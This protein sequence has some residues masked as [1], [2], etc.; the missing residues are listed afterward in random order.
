[1]IRVL[2]AEDSPTLRYLIRS[3][4]E[5]DP[6]LEVVGAASNGEEAW[7]LLRELQPDIM[8]TDI[9]MPKLDGYGLIRKAMAEAPLPIVVLTSTASDAELGVTFH[10][11]EAGALMVTGKPRGL[12]GADPQADKLIRQVKAMARVKV[13]RRRRQLR[14][15]ERATAPR[16]PAAHR[17]G[18]R[19]VRV[20][21]MGASTG[22][23]PAIQLIL[24]RLPADL[25]VPIVVV[26]HI[27]AGFMTGMA[28]W[29]N[30]TT[31]PRV[32]IAEDGAALRAGTVY[33]APDAH[34][35]RVAAD[36][37]IR[38]SDCAPVGGHRPS[39]T[40][41]FE[42]LARA[43][44]PSAVGVLLTGMGSDGASGM[45]DLHDAGAMTLAQNEETCVVFGMPKQAITLGGV[46]EVL[47]VDRIPG[48]LVELATADAESYRRTEHAASSGR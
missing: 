21:G 20:I 48:R 16:R 11:V 32:C 19:R 13:V 14:K 2:I 33:L 42:S 28:R 36:G 46:D 8:T 41:L 38:L 1:M 34:H 44:G 5:S 37:L 30:D 6:D 29:L 24:K 40:V 39:A 15:T 23:P 22:G 27:S 25:P 3:V 17:P 7:A 47:A 26:Q 9:R 45:K 18:P 43:Y 35:T 31:P 10:A 12:P 4:L